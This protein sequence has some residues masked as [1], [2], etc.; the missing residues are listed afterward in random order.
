M[1]GLWL[2]GG[3]GGNLSGPFPYLVSIVA[4]IHSLKCDLVGYWPRDLA[5]SSRCADGREGLTFASI[6]KEISKTLWHD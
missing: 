1:E 3:G 2:G 6:A 4:L 5:V